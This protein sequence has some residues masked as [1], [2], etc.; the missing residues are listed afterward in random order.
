MGMVRA[1]WNRWDAW[2]ARRAEDVVDADT[3]SWLDSLSTAEDHTAGPFDPI[4]VPGQ[5]Y[6]G[7]HR[8]MPDE[9]VRGR[10]T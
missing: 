8:R 3:A 10:A 7:R 4:R 5:R 1:G 9:P 6:Q 2:R